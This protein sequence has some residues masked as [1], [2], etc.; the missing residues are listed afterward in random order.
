MIY[1]GILIGSVF[2]LTAFAVERI[3]RRSGVPSVIVMI[4]L[5]L[6]AE[7]L[8]RPM[9][10]VA[11]ELK[12]M[13][14]V[15]GT[16][17]LVLIVLEGALDLELRRERLGLAATAFGVAVAGFAL[18]TGAFAVL[19]V[20]LLHISDYR[21]LVLAIPFAVISSAIAIPGSHFLEQRAREFVIYESSVSDIVGVLVFFAL[22]HSD[23]TVRGFLTDLAGGGLLSLLL[24]I[25]CSVMLVL[26]TTRAAAHVRHIPL[27]A[28]LF[29]L[30][31]GGELLH[32]SP[33]LMVL[34]FGLLLNNRS[35]L[36]RVA[37]LRHVSEQISAATVGEFRVLVQELTFAVRG[38]FFFLLGY[39]TDLHDFAVAPSWIAAAAI[40][41]VVYAARNVL[42][43][44]TDRRLAAALTWIAPR[45]LVT[46]LL[47]L[48]AAQRIALPVY[49]D[50][51]VRLVVILSATFLALARRAGATR[52]AHE[53][54]G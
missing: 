41:L 53:P 46:V 35:V 14:P 50:G 27:L 17:G 39:S 3:D 36:D 40:L 30:Y 2:L 31:A 32:L 28:G 15:A 6:L 51:T 9:G 38:F 43:R 24:A 25:A 37:G 26:V 1:I 44:L 22:V 12:S 54:A 47:Y 8:L 13:V 10:V 29:A 20:Q 23:A 7:P 52:L 42:L 21:A 33:L 45:G 4:V 19:A 18:C 5:G 34:L 48:E 11:G 49:L 16:I